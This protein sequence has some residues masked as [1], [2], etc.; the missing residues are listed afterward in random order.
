MYGNP[1][2]IP[3]V[4]VGAGVPLQ[5]TQA[6]VAQSSVQPNMAPVQAGSLMQVPPGTMVPVN[7]GGRIVHVPTQPVATQSV[8]HMSM[9]P[10]QQVQEIQEVPQYET[11]S[12]QVPIETTQEQYIPPPMEGVEPAPQYGN[13]TT[14]ALKTLTPRVVRNQLPPQ[15]K[16]VVLPA[17]IVRQVLPPIGPP[18]TPAN[19][20]IQLPQP[21]LP[22][23][24]T[25]NS[26]VVPQSTIQTVQSTYMVPQ[27][28]PTVQVSVPPVIS[29]PMYSSASVGQVGSIAVPN[30]TT[31]S[32]PQ[33]ST[34]NFGTTSITQVTP[35]Y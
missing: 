10:V 33:L 31:T 23:V 26:V 14:P 15:H 6:S 32:V 5:S 8:M 17:K 18:P 7:V 29:Q 13:L 16:Q 4:Q 2:V 12:F 30:Y 1:S 9:Q 28:I 20:D 24:Q 3:S 19:L 21:T 11:Q 35:Q 27:Q 25:V 22:P 34:P